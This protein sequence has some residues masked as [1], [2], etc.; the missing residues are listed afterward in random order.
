[1][2]EVNVEKELDALLGDVEFDLDAIEALFA[3]QTDETDDNET[4]EG[5][6]PLAG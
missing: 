4:A 3:D 5:E 2:Q 6:A 1:M